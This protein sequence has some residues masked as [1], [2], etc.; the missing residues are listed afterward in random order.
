MRA[1]IR[2]LGALKRLANYV[3][4]GFL[5]SLCAGASIGCDSNRGRAPATDVTRSALTFSVNIDATALTE[6]SLSVYTVTGLF[7]SKTLQQLQLD[8]GTYLLQMQN[9][10]ANIGDFTV[11]ADGTI[12]YDSSMNTEFSGR[13]TSTLIVSGHS[14]NLDGTALTEQH[15][16]IYCVGSVFDSKTS[17]SLQLVA[18]EYLVQMQNGGAN[19][20]AFTANA[21][22]TINYDTSLDTEFSGRG[23][24]TIA[25]LGHAI[26][27]LRSHLSL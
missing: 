16:S 1:S 17:Q 2:T 12:D 5:M 7:D 9:G 20:G 24:S 27:R 25:V 11:N 3:I 19:I 10:G 6:Q 18:G 22:G 26:Q 14:V 21:D 4:I 23:T 8:P 15:L 13:G